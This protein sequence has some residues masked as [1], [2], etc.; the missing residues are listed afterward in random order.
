MTFFWSLALLWVACRAELPT[1][2]DK[3]A[4]Y[5]LVLIGA[6]IGLPRIVEDWQEFLR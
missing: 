3:C 2:R 4:V 5:A 1:K 6:V